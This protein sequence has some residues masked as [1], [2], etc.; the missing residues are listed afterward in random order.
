MKIKICQENTSKCNIFF[1][2][3]I[4]KAAEKCTR[5]HKK[6]VACVHGSSNYKDI[7]P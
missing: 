4:D 7:K 6:L 2:F 1:S 5:N 3:T